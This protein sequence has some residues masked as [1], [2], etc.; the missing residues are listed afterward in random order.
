MI[1][2]VSYKALRT[3]RRNPP[4]QVRDFI[5][6]LIPC[7]APT[8]IEIRK[9]S[10]IKLLLF[11]TVYSRSFQC[12]VEGPAVIS[13]LFPRAQAVLSATATPFILFYLS[14]IRATAA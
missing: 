13:V 7:R 14:I 12:L 6:I 5:P 11:C 9:L 10:T 4:E 8:P 3:A 2:H 1:I